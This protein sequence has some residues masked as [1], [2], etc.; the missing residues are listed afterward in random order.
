[1]RASLVLAIRKRCSVS[2]A[3]SEEFSCSEPLLQ[4]GSQ[5]RQTVVIM[6][7]VWCRF[8]ENSHPDLL[9]SSAEG[10]SLWEQLFW[11]GSFSLLTLNSVD[12]TKGL[13]QEL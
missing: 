13:I 9:H 7:E 11:A 4:R 5:S 10:C 3:S 2:T 12:V 8:L 1:M 6:L